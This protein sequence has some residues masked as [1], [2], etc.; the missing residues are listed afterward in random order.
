MSGNQTKT[1]I[2]MHCTNSCLCLH[3]EYTVLIIPFKEGTIEL[4][5]VEKTVAQ[6]KRG[7]GWLPY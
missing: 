3:F 6:G 7:M 5:K 1:G 2:I 4:E